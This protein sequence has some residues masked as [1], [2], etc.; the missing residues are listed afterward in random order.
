[1]GRT[2]YETHAF[3]NIFCHGDRRLTL[4][5]FFTIFALTNHKKNTNSYDTNYDY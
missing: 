1:M 3:V 2:F 4:C 5:D